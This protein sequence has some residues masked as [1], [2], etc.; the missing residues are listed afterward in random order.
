MFPN[1]NFISFLYAIHSCKKGEPVVECA[2]DR[3]RLRFRTERPFQGRI[4][5]K[6]FADNEAT[7]NYF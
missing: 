2:E 3:I 7:Y 1:S 5:V 4:F 6:G